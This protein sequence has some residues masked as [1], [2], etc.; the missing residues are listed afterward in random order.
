LKTP[1]VPVK[2]QINTKNMGELLNL[3]LVQ[4]ERYRYKTVYIENQRKFI[5]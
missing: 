4:A 2:A 5:D 3:A 1:S